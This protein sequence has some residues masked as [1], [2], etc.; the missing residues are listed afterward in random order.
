[1]AQETLESLIDIVRSNVTMNCKLPYTLG[2]ENIERII[3][4]NAMK[5]FYKEYKYATHRTYYYIDLMSMY[6]DNSSG[7]QFLT[8]P[9]EIMAVRWIY[10]VNYNEMRNLGYLLPNNSIA[11]GQ[12]SQPF[13]AAI[14]VSEFGESIS[15]AQ[16]LQDALNNF[17]KS[18]VKF[19]F[20]PTSKRFEV[21][22]SNTRNLILEVYAEVPPE[23]L[24]S[25]FYFIQYVTG[26]AMMDYATHLSFTDM[27]LAGNSKINTDRIYDR[28][29][30]MVTE[31]K[32][33]IKNTTKSSFFFN[34]T[35]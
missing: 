30:K 16:S 25:D 21:Q 20:D 10:M 17:S 24:Y 35:N 29:D 27:Q 34:K 31:V 15:V 8:L 18:T 28:G 13:I 23:F 2:D 11:L 6:K 22:T 9:E 14:N 19:F 7:V 26:Y 4:Y 12:T 32:E 1:M 33:Y 5:Y 3:V